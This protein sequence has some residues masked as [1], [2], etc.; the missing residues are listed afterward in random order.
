MM[1]KSKT[2]VSVGRGHAT[3]NQTHLTDVLEAVN[4]CKTL[5]ETRRR[6]LCSSIKRVSRLLGDD[7]AH[8]ALDLPAISAKLPPSAPPPLV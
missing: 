6:D 4:G 5:P 8:I 1:K 7:P 3:P 2:K